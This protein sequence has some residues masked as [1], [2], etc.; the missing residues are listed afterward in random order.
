[1]PATTR[2]VLDRRR[3]LAAGG[4][5][6]ALLVAERLAGAWPAPAQRGGYPFTLGVASGDPAPGGVV[7]WTRLA[8]RPLLADGGMAARAVPVDW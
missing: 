2:K 4:A 1:M 6:A 7:L 3:L 5:A 8:P